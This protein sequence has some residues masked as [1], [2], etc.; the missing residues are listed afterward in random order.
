MMKDFAFLILTLFARLA[1]AGEVTFDREIE[2][3]DRGIYKLS[4]LA[5]FK[6]TSLSLQN[7][8][9][10]IEIKEVTSE[11][12]RTL[13]RN[14]KS[15]EVFADLK[16]I[17]P[18]N[19]VLKK[20]RG[21]SGAEFRRK[22]E[23]L[24]QTQCASC[25]FNFYSIRDERVN[26]GSS[27]KIDPSTVKI[28]PS[29]LVTLIDDTARTTWVPV[30]LKVLKKVLVTKHSVLAD[31]K[32]TSDN[33]ELKLIDITNLRDPVEDLDSLKSASTRRFIA[34]GQGLSM[35]DVVRA[36]WVKRGQTVKVLMVGGDYE[37]SSMAMA[38]ENGR[39]GDTIRIKSQ[40]SGKLLTAE[41]FAE[42]VVRV[43]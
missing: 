28:Q 1:Q 32:L 23:N 42:G 21:Y 19:L 2:V 13:L 29:F 12:L 38:E 4:D 33:L 40:E 3:S 6:N 9:A 15:A 20:N 27:W 30:Q 37:I 43:R 10:K 18:E 22:V 34:A 8:L 17:I 39:A 25:E 24:L 7:E 14:R 31:E 5:H 26:I 35:V 41:V 16:F 11:S 36:Q